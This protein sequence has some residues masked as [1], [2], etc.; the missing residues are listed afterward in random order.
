MSFRVIWIKEETVLA[1]TP[2]QRREEA[3][4]HAQ[5]QYDRQH[6]QHGATSVEVLDDGGRV[7]Y[8]Y[9]GTGRQSG[10]SLLPFCG[11]VQ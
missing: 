10:G 3:E 6:E 4:K 8:R 2:F 11:T 7:V 1:T 5:E 9:M